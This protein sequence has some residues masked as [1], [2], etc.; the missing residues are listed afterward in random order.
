MFGTIMVHFNVIVKFPYSKNTLGRISV[1]QQEG[2][3]ILSFSERRF[4]RRK[5]WDESS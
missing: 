4:V 1:E 2:R 5:W 3:F